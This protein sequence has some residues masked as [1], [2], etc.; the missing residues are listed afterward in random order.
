VDIINEPVNTHWKPS[1]LIDFPLDIVERILGDSIVDET[2]TFVDRHQSIRVERGE[3]FEWARLRM[4][5]T[6]IVDELLS[7][8]EVSAV[9]AHLKTSFSDSFALITDS[10]LTRLVSCTPVAIFPTA[11]QQV[12]NELPNELLYQNG[13]ANDAFT[14][15]LSGKITILVGS[16]NFRADL[17]SW[18]VLGKAALENRLWVP[19]FTAFVSDGPCRCIQIRYDA[20]A[21]AVDASVAERRALE[22]KVSEN[23]CPS[24]DGDGCSVGE[25]AKSATSSSD[26]HNIH[27]RR[28]PVLEKLF[29]AGKAKGK[30]AD[31][32]RRI[33]ATSVQLTDSEV[34]TSNSE[35]EPSQ[36]KKVASS[37]TEKAG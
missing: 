36:V 9:T 28:G 32:D 29:N 30:G 31:N 34:V 1:H 15:V 10:Q 27:N 33:V 22:T 14:L 35:N 23:M 3:G 21:A 2:D 26:G 19:D 5:D 25:S 8:S 37:T 17:S 20:Y 16:E 6:K 24:V 11:T 12:G 13:V 4:L 18:A 7:P